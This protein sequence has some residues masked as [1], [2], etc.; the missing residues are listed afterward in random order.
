MLKNGFK[1]SDNI[2]SNDRKFT[3]VAEHA[4]FQGTYRMQSAAVENCW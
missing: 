1:N 4:L 3:M 2:S